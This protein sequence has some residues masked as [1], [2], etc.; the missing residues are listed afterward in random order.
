MY[1]A[2]FPLYS[3]TMR[4]VDLYELG[5]EVIRSVECCY[6][7]SRTLNLD[8]E[9]MCGTLVNVAVDNSDAS[10]LSCISI[11]ELL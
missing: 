11:L 3:T 6:A 7:C 8:K 10:A 1:K 5:E 9:V 2:W 4:A